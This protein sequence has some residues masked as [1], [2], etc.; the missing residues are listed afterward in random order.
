[1]GNVRLDYKKLTQYCSKLLIK[2]G[3]NEEEA[4]VITTS[5]VEADMSGVGSHGVSRLKIYMKR[6]EEGVV[7]KKEK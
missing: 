7:S 3:V 4:S 2:Q 5:L 1:M 6:M